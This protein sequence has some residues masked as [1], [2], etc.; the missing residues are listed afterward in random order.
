MLRPPESDAAG[1]PH[2]LRNDALQPIVMGR[3]PRFHI[4][5]RVVKRI[6]DA[7][8][9]DDDVVVATTTTDGRYGTVRNVSTYVGRTVP[10]RT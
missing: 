2:T 4:G 1:V 9:Y 10:Y 5:K 3:Q 6:V 8:T 7:A